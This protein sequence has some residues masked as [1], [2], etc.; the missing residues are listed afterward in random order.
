MN[1][2]R[3]QAMFKRSRHNNLSFFAISQEFYELQ[4]ER[5]ELMEISTTSFNYRFSE[6]FKVF[7]KTKQVWM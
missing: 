2:P 4:R 1:D 7:I 3:I 6:M 5:S